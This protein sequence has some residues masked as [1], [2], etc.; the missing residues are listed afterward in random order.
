MA[1]NTR[2]SDNYQGQ[3]VKVKPSPNPIVSIDPSPNIIY[4]QYVG[5]VFAS[6]AAAN[7]ATYSQ[8][9]NVI[10]V[11]STAHNIATTI[12]NG[13]NIYLSGATITT[14]ANIDAGFYSNLQVIDANTFTCVSPISQ[15]GSGT[16]TTL[17]SATTVPVSFLIPARSIAENGF[18][19]VS[20]VSICNASAGTKRMSFLYGNFSFKNPAPASTTLMVQETHRLQNL[21]S[22]QKQIALPAGSV[23]NS[24]PITVAPIYGTVDSSIDQLITIQI[25][26]NTASDYI[27]LEHITISTFY[28]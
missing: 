27:T 22:L 12:N 19:D 14:G 9:G 25:T 28:G 5:F 13:K 16:L 2:T 15:S 17:T 3:I 8:S 20:H 24:G 18:I 21:N 7:A 26:L 6:L 11:T 10:T 4:N 1:I 23:G